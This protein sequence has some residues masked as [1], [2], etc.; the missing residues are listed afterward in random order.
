M[1]FY[2]FSLPVLVDLG[3]PALLD[4][5]LLLNLFFYGT[6]LTLEALL[7]PHNLALEVEAAALLGVVGVK[8]PLVPLEHLLDVGLAAGWGLDV[9]D[10]AGLIEGHARR[11]RGAARGV[12]RLG[13]G[14]LVGRCGRG[15][16]VGGHKGAAEDSGACEEGCDDELVRLRGGRRVC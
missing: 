16:L 7:C 1:L 15:L 12:A 10:L 14:A 9:E 3:L 2:L 6:N 5:G 13:L 4:F 11:E 8:Q